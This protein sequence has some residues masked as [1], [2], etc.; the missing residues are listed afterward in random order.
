[1]SEDYCKTSFKLTKSDMDKVMHE[2]EAC[3]AGLTAKHHSVTVN[4]GK[5]E[6]LFE[7]IEYNPEVLSHLHQAISELGGKNIVTEMY[8]EQVDETAF[9]TYAKDELKSFDSLKELKAYEKYIAQQVDTSQ[10]CYKRS[11]ENDYAICRFY[12]SNDKKRTLIKD[13]FLTLLESNVDNNVDN[14]EGF[15]DM[16]NPVFN[17]KES[18]DVG[19]C[20]WGYTKTI[21]NGYPK[22][23]DG[24]VIIHRGFKDIVNKVEFVSE[25]NDYLYVGFDIADMNLGKLDLV[26]LDYEGE[27]KLGNMLANTTKVLGS[28]DG[29]KQFMIKYRFTKHPEAN[30]INIS[31]PFKCIDYQDLTDDDFWE[32]NYNTY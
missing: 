6:C 8:F 20:H 4:R 21:E 22:E 29:V 5:Y 17:S 28:L 14:I 3:V 1:M 13:I 30:E 23:E 9:L 26:N 10:F 12:C 25:Q 32:M 27:T 15:T 31:E 19:W 2:V 16:A 18:Y 7:F 24:K 11:R